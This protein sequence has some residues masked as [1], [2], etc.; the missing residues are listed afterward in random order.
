M[1]KE[2]LEIFRY[3]E[4]T[5]GE[6]GAC[7][8][9]EAITLLRPIFHNYNFVKTW[10]IIKRSY[11]YDMY[12]IVFKPFNVNY[13]PNYNG[14][15]S[16]KQYLHKRKD[17]DTMIIT[18]EIMD[19]AKIHFNVI[20]WSKSDYMKINGK[21]LNHYYITVQKVKK[22][23][24]DKMT[25]H[26]YCIK[27]SKKRHMYPKNDILIFDKKPDYV[28]ISHRKDLVGEIFQKPLKTFKVKLI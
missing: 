24:A 6:S 19:C 14:M 3:I 10:P 28:K 26:H 11:E 9:D 18:R 27:E 2:Q 20:L 12:Y 23:T 7:L 17:F 4:P 1:D 8:H 15:K 25:V 5:E 16:V 13:D 21:H 22:T